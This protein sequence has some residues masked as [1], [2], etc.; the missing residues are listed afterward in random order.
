MDHLIFKIN[1]NPSEIIN[2][3]IIN[4]VDNSYVGY[5]INP[6]LLEGYSTYVKSLQLNYYTKKYLIDNNLVSKNLMTKTNFTNNQFEVLNMD[7][8]IFNLHLYRESIRSKYISIN[9]NITYS[10]WI[11]LNDFL[12]DD[13]LINSQLRYIYFI[14]ILN[15]FNNIIEDINKLGLDINRDIEKL[16][17]N[18]P[19]KKEV[20]EIIKNKLLNKWYFILHTIDLS[21]FN[22]NIYINHILV[23]STNKKFSGSIIPG[24]SEITFPGNISDIRIYSKILNEKE[25]LNM[26]NE[27]LVNNTFDLTNAKLKNSVDDY[28]YTYIFSDLFP[29]GDANKFINTNNS[30]FK[31]ETIPQSEI[32]E[33]NSANDCLNT[34]KNMKSCTSYSYD[35]KNNLCYHYK[36]IF[37]ENVYE[38]VPNVVSGYSLNYPFD[39]NLLNNDQQN[40][41]RK[42]L[43]NTFLKNNFSLDDSIN[44]KNCLNIDNQGEK[45]LFKTDVKCIYDTFHKNNIKVNRTFE[46][47]KYNEK[48]EYTYSNDSFYDTIKKSFYDELS[49]FINSLNFSDYIKEYIPPPKPKEINIQDKPIV[50][51]DKTMEEKTASSIETAPSIEKKLEDN[52]RDILKSLSDNIIYTVDGDKIEKFTNN[53]LNNTYKMKNH[54]FIFIICILFII[55]II[56]FMKK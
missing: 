56:Y 45:T 22:E 39:F 53:Q 6:I 46:E 50:K 41:I 37:P 3:Q 33:L 14:F 24:Y 15:N 32:K 40:I 28:L 44:I 48:T 13:F 7:T 51:S 35:Q 10:Y 42:S 16:L 52:N 47:D 31:F 9:K 5:V 23:S 36:Y 26:Y 1:F 2:N 20:Y 29:Q 25:I 8:K 19:K 49:K 43:S 17:S 11:Y 55:A 30:S 4:V 18:H 34:C 21:N 12:N 54:F 38:N 27:A